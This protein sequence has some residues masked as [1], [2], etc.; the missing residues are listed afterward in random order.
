MII[1]E[2]RSC[3]KPF[4][5]H[6]NGTFLKKNKTHFDISHIVLTYEQVGLRVGWYDGSTVFIIKGPGNRT[7]K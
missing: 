6:V 3:G 1:H 2:S 4:T 7:L 5:A